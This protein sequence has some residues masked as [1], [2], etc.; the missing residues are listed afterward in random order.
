M[1]TWDAAR[2]GFRCLRASARSNRCAKPSLARSR[3]SP[4]CEHKS[5]TK[6]R[7]ATPAGRLCGGLSPSEE[8]WIRCRTSRAHCSNALSDAASALLSASPTR[9]A[10]ET[11]RSP[12]WRK[13]TNRAG[14]IEENPK[15]GVV[16]P[17]TC[18]AKA[19]ANAP[20]AASSSPRASISRTSVHSVQASSGPPRSKS[21]DS[22]SDARSIQVLWPGRDPGLATKTLPSAVSAVEPPAGSRRTRTSGDVGATLGASATPLPIEPPATMTRGSSATPFF[23]GVSWA[24]SPEDASPGPASMAPSSE[25]SLTKPVPVPFPPLCRSDSQTRMWE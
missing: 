22:R 25:A 11:S 10:A 18:A 3:E 24:P 14:M 20:F 21:G 7:R 15:W 1:S 17:S 6:R 16:V 9:Q 8:F 12:L 4:T 19:R 23:G 2:V 13:S 5:R